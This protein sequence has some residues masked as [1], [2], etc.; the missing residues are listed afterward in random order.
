MDGLVTVGWLK[1]CHCN[2][3]SSTGQFRIE[4]IERGIDHMKFKCWF[5]PEPSCDV[6]SK[7]WEPD[8]AELHS[9]TNKLA[10]ALKE[11]DA[12]ERKYTE[13]LAHNNDLWNAAAKT[14]GGLK[15]LRSVNHKTG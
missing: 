5:Y 13:S 7:P 11:R 10:A 6:C 4:C 8:N 9:E 1:A 12:F 14:P 2:G 3:T 15:L